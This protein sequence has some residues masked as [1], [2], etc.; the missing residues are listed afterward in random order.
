M[1]ACHLPRE[2][3]QFPFHRNL[4]EEVAHPEGHR[5]HEDRFAVL[6]DPDEVELVM[7]RAMRTEA[8]L[9]A[10]NISQNPS[11]YAGPAYGWGGFHPRAH[12]RGPQ[13]RT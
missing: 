4:A 10:G 5:P 12:A 8:D 6:R 13:P 3:G 2:D 9:H 1:V 7:V 11:G